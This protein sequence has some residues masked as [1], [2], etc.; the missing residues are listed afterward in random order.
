MDI[1]LMSSHALLG[2]PDLALRLFTKSIDGSLFMDTLRTREVTLHRETEAPFHIDGDPVKMPK[3]IHIRI[4]ADG[5]RVL[6]E[7]RF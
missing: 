4:V 1:C 7:K 3:D 2:A 5:L 6:A